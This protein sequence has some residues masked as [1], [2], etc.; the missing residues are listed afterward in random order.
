MNYAKTAKSPSH[1]RG[2]SL[3]NLSIKSR[4]E[5]ES[6]V[7]PGPSRIKTRG[8]FV[9]LSLFIVKISRGQNTLP[10]SEFFIFGKCCRRPIRSQKNTTFRN[11][12]RIDVIEKHYCK[13]SSHQ[14]IYIAINTLIFY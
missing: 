2:C 5:Y 11:S 6:P 7:P 14:K 1:P 4:M 12:I 9:K 10:D 3:D 8:A 13:N